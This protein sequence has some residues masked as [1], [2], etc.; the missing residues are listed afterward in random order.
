MQFCWGQGA[1]LAEIKSKEEED[2]VD[3][4]L[5]TGVGY[6]LGLTDYPTEGINLLAADSNSISPNVVVCLSVVCD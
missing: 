3:P 4:H 1:Y 5:I 6:W 2:L